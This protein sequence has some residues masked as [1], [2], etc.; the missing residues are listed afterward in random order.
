MI[1]NRSDARNALIKHDGVLI[2]MLPDAGR[3]ILR[4]DDISVGPLPLQECLLA[5][6]VQARIMRVPFR[7]RCRVDRSPLKPLIDLAQRCRGISA[8]DAMGRNMPKRH[9]LFERIN[10][11]VV[12][13]SA[14]LRLVDHG[15]PWDV[16]VNR[17]NEVRLAQNPVLTWLIPLASLL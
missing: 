12:Y 7:D 1:K 16:A 15:Y 9:L 6:V 14:P 2:Q 5:C 13:L 17:Q 8:T 3:E 4:R 11:D 10:V